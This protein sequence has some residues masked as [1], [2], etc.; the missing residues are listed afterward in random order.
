MC[1]STNFQTTS[2][3]GFIHKIDNFDLHT[4]TVVSKTHFHMKGYA[5]EAVLISNKHD[6]SITENG[7]PKKG[8]TL[9][10]RNL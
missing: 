10:K 5:T 7:C 3:Q 6:T 8:R 2:Q 4:K 1:I 9:I